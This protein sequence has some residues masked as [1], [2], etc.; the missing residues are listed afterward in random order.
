[1]NA[2]ACSGE[3]NEFQKCNF[4]DSSFCGNFIGGAIV[5]FLRHFYV[6]AN[7]TSISL[8]S[9]ELFLFLAMFYLIF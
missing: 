6:P 4:G 8:V 5:L 2:S 7:T 9:I 3:F 1:M